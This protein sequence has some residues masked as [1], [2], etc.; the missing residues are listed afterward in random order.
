MEKI[1]GKGTFTIK[2]ITQEPPSINELKKML[3]FQQGNL[4][5][6]FNTSGQLYRK[7]HLNEKLN[8]MPADKALELLTQEG[9]LVKRP[10]L[11]GKDFGLTGFKEVEWANIMN[12]NLS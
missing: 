5:K 7:L 12:S 9:M 6:L 10:F 3:A 11:I 2:E 1:K 4:K 8:D